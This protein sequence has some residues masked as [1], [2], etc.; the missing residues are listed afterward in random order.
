MILVNT[1]VLWGLF[2]GY[3]LVFCEVFR[4]DS[5]TVRLKGKPGC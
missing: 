1:F 4:F 3:K 2:V 5:G